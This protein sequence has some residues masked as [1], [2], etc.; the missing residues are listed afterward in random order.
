LTYYRNH[1][2]NPTNDNGRAS[3]PF[4][5]DLQGV[6]KVYSGDNL[7]IRWLAGTRDQHI[8]P[9]HINIAKCRLQLF[10]LVIVDTTYEHAVKRVICPLNNWK[11]GSICADTIANTEHRTKPDPLNGT[12]PILIGSWIERLRPS[13]EIYDYARIL[14]WNQLQDQG[15]K[16]LPEMSE[17]P[18]YMQTLAKYTGMEITDMHF[19]NIPRVSLRNEEHF[20]PPVQFCRKMKRIWMSNPDGEW[21]RFAFNIVD[22][23]HHFISPRLLV[24][25]SL[26]TE[27]PNV[28]GIGSLAGWTIQ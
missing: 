10:D 4:W 23:C 20:H 7:N 24:H 16:D 12:D 22:P 25:A 19:R 9:D 27:V 2:F 5:F 8:T 11:G 18:S 17:I 21:I 1:K 6:Q 26:K 3:S 15:V 28:Y 14:S 13:F